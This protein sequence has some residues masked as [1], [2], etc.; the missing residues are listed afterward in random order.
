MQFRIGR[1][2]IHILAFMVA[3]C[4][5][6][7]LYPFVVPFF[8][9]AYLQEQS[10]VSLFIALMLGIG[11]LQD[12][13][14]LLKY[15]MVLLFLLI[16]LHRTDRQK[17]FE[18]N[19][20][21]AMAAGAVLCA[22][23]MPYQFLATGEDQSLFYAILEGV[24]TMCFVLVFEQGFLGLRVGTN[25]MFATNERFVGIFAL[26]AVALFGCPA[27]EQPVHILLF[28]SSYLLLTLA[29]R[30]EAGVGIAAGSITG[31]VLAFATKNIAY[32]AVMIL[33]AGMVVVLRGLGKI[34]MLLSFSSCIILL[35]MLYEQS[36]LLPNMLTA[37]LA[38]T[39]VFF[40]T[41]A[42]WMKKTAT[43]GDFAT[44]LSQD[45]L[46]Q[47][48]ARNRIRNFGQAFVSMKQILEYNEELRE[49]IAPNGLS[50]M[51]LSG[52]GISLLNAVESQSNRLMELRC[53][54]IRQIGQI[55]EIIEH[56][57]R[58]SGCQCGSR[59]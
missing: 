10:S 3:R 53:N 6:L 59:Q 11:S 42:K 5:M 35:G 2:G 54:F 33:I 22:I 13:T 49:P 48:A 44:G 45:L 26:M 51:Y 29:Y 47:E 58:A 55:G 25:R 56:R 24:I 21:I 1:V 37:V 41:P 28:L 17:I 30:F 15:L 27:V 4:R 57:Q 31:F 9:G 23:S 43:V 19:L 40:L 16:I 38:A 18:D 14:A 20:Q 7:G 34:G 32:L 39:T 46:V 8:M 12:G 52:D 36:L 50:N